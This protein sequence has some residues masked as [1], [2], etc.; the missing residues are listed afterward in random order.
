M[1]G[2]LIIET[3]GGKDP[4]LIAIGNAPKPYVPLHKVLRSAR[5]MEFVS[6]M[7]RDLGVNP[8]ALRRPTTDGRR[9]LLAKP[10]LIETGELHGVQMWFGPA[11][12]A[13]PEPEPAGAWCFNLTTGK[14]NR[15]DDL[16]D[17]YGVSPADRANEQAIAGAFTRLVTNR[18]EG[19]ALA[20]I[21]RAEIGFEHQAVW[22]LRRDDGALRA[23]HFAC[24]A[25]ESSIEPGE[26]LIRGIT[27]DIGA[28]AETPAAPPPMVLEHNMLAASAEDGEFRAIVN[29]RTLKIIRWV[30]EPMPD[31]AWLLLPGEP[32]PA[33]HPDDIDAAREM[34][35]GLARGRTHGVVRLRTVDGDWQPVELRAALMALDQHT[36]AGLVTLRK[37]EDI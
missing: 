34:S 14:S 33:L 9:I 5:S 36:T 6:E 30:G 21:V 32:E 20:G 4:S 31:I 3:F 7:V 11:D 18:D 12:D 27:Q 1:G 24:R 26:R 17:L 15:S 22:T 16:L 13:V 35:R 10:L 29:L 8:R 37:L 23:A 25:V 19:E 28:A 2:W